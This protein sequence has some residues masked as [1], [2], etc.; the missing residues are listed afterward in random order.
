MAG[1]IRARELRALLG[2]AC[3]FA[4]ARELDGFFH[5]TLGA[6]GYQLFSAP[7][8]I[9]AAWHAWRSRSVLP[10][11]TAEFV[12]TPAAMLVF[13]GALIVLVH[14]QILGQKELWDALIPTGD[15]MTVKKTVEEA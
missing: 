5:G 13:A 6:H 10:H 11:Q 2:L 12:A 8:A 9:A 15:A 14:A 4:V 1:G 3:L 7:V